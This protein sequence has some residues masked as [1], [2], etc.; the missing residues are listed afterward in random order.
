MDLRFGKSFHLLAQEGHLAKSALLSG[1]DF[2]LRAE[3]NANKDGQFYAAFF[4]LSI[5]IERLLK[6][7]VVAQHMLE[8][9]FVSPTPKQ[10]KGTMDTIF[11]PCTPAHCL[12]G[13]STA[14]PFTPLKNK[15]FSYCPF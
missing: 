1:F 2:L 14:C 8:N 10:L 11:W 7:V 12:L 3:A 4:Q 6:L 5:G 13:K 15:L 9:N